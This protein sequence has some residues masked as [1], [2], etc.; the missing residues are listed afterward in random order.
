[1]IVAYSK[2]G[3]KEEA[4]S[5]TFT[6]ADELRYADYDMMREIWGQYRDG[7]DRPNDERFYKWYEKIKKNKCFKK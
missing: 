1:M 3:V 6:L 2:D 5:L 4:T 7:R